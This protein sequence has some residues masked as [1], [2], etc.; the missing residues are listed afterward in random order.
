[1][2]NRRL[3][4]FL[5][6]KIILL[7]IAGA[8]AGCGQ[9]SGG[10]LFQSGQIVGGGTKEIRDAQPVAG[11]LPNASLLQ[12]GG[13]GRAALVY[14]NP[15]ANFSQYN[16]LLLDPVTIWT[17]PDSQLNSVPHNQQQAA[18]DRFHADLYNALNASTV[19]TSNATYGATWLTP[20]QIL[21]SRIFKF[22]VQLDF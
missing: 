11:F 2:V 21:T 20:T 10:G 8:V 17:A 12:P 3:R 14:R 15:T 4:H 22:G 1:M 13:S 5:Y 7:T 9:T 16:K 18:A 6:H 19:I